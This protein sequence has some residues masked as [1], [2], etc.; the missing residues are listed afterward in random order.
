M[1]IREIR[2]T[3]ATMGTREIREARGATKPSTYG[4]RLAVILSCVCPP[5]GFD[6]TSVLNVAIRCA[7]FSMHGRFLMYC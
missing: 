5:R 3:T 6:E 2:G 1:R 7:M 4:A